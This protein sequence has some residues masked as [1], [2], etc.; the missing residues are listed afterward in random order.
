MSWSPQHSL[1]TF[2]LLLATSAGAYEGAAPRRDEQA[3]EAGVP[4]PAPQLTKAPELL[5]FVEAAYPPEAL[6]RN[7][8]AQ[9]AFLIDIDETGKVMQAEVTRSA[10]PEFDAAAREAVLGLLFSPA[11]VDGKPAPVRI[12]YVYHF[13]PRP[14]PPPEPAAVAAAEKPVNFQG[15]VLQRGT[16]DPIPNATVYLP[17]QELSTETDSE[18]RFELRGV[19][20]GKLRWRSPSR[21]TRSSSPPRRYGRAKSPS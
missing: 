12:E 19:I 10:G 20:P 16:R 14:P 1:C 17:E 3:A 11:E 15:R 13:V 18:G 9:V 21:S 6:A 2:V 8:A 4:P 7:E 5:H